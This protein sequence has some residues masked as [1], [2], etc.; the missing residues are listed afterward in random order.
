MR[1]DPDSDPRSRPSLVLFDLDDTLCD[2]YSS[3]RVRLRFA[4][5]A[6]LDGDQNID[7]DG[8][9]EQAAAG[10]IGRTS[11]FEELLAQYG[12]ED[13]ERCQLVVDRYLSDRFRGLELFDDAIE[14]VTLMRRVARVGLI[15]NGPSRIQRDK[16]ARL[17]IHD[18][19]DEILVSEEEG[20]WKPDPV[21]FQRALE[22]F[23]VDAKRAVYVGDSPEHDVAGAQSAGITSVWINRRERNW[24]G[25]P[26]ADYEIKR[27][28]ELVDVLGLTAFAGT[29]EST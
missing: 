24:P 5:N 11:H 6:A 22:G 21:I 2:H 9:V 1:H 28:T 3:L 17:A 23:D 20:V 13:P 15:T 4:F 10:S 26:R 12:I 8:L 27:L 16:I 18:L 14:I 29:T 19:F 7:I 25:G